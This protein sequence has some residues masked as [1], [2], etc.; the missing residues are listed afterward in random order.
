[1]ALLTPLASPW[2]PCGVTVPAETSRRGPGILPAA[3]PLRRATTASLDPPRSATVVNPAFSV[4][5]A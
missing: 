4:T 1:M 5:R 2:P 3:I